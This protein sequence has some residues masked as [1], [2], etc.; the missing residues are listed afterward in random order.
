MKNKLKIAAVVVAVVVG[1]VLYKTSF[2]KKKAVEEK[3]KG[4]S[5]ARANSRPLP[6]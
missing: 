2:D 5:K 3:K 1:M 6:N 4:T